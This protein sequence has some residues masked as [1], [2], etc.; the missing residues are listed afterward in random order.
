MATELLLFSLET[1]R[2]YAEGVGQAL[3]ITLAPIE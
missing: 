2:T 3:G 1:S